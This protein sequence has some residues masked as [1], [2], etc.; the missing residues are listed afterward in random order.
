MPQPLTA[1]RLLGQTLRRFPQQVPGMFAAAPLAFVLFVLSLPAA[2][3]LDQF[4]GPIERWLLLAA[5][6]CLLSL[7]R[8]ALAWQRHLAQAPRPSLRPD[9]AYLRMV[10]LIAGAVLLVAGLKSLSTTLGVALYFKMPDTPST[11]FLTLMLLL[12]LV[13]WLPVMHRMG[14]WSLSLPQ[15]ALTDRFGWQ[16]S[17]QALRR[18]VWPFSLMLLMLIASTAVATGSLTTAS[19]T[20]WANA[21]ITAGAALILSVALILAFAMLCAAAYRDRE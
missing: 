6:V 19:R 9:A 16:Q 14:A 18:R 21:I 2:L 13:V 5:V 1:R 10:V 4:G 7:A 11:V 17:R 3:V 8:L 12:W 15:V 20:G